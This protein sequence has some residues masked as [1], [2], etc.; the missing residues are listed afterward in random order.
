MILRTCL[1]VTEDPDHHVQFS[2]VLYEIT[3]DMVVLVVSNPT[4]ALDLLVQKRHAPDYIMLD[5]SIHGLNAESFFAT[6]ESD[7]D[8]ADIPF[9]IWGDFSQMPRLD[10]KRVAAFIED[11]FSYSRLR[12]I[13][14]KI[15]NE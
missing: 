5:L 10:S 8:L 13:L 2:E 9:I 12:G 14:L 4:K 11:E 15:L 3:T 7:P 6:L 1:L